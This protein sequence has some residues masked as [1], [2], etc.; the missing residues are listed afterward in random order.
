EENST[1]QG[2]FMPMERTVYTYSNLVKI[3]ILTKG[4]DFFDTLAGILKKDSSFFIL[5][6]F[7]SI[8]GLFHFFVKNPGAKSYLFT[9]SCG[10]IGIQRGT[11][12]IL[13]QS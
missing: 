7:Y 3:L 8:P 6:G 11:P 4:V 1:F 12:L 2:I 10:R 9:L 13:K 5:S